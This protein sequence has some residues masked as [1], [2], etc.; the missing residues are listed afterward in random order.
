MHFRLNRKTLVIL[1][2]VSY[3]CATQYEGEI[4]GRRA[5]VFPRAS[6]NTIWRKIAYVLKFTQQT[7]TPGGL[8]VAAITYS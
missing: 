7:A 5:V 6:R 3:K 4:A 2:Y 1:I 8:T